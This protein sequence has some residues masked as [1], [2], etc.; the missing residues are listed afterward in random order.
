MASTPVINLRKGHA[1]RHNNEVCIVT[2]HELKTPPRMASYVQMS[3]RSVTT[4]KVFNLRLT[5]N[6]SLEGVMLERIPHE[7]SYK[8]SSGYHFLNPET[9][10][11]TIVPE[12]LVEPV[13]NYLID[14]QLYTILLA[15]GSV[16][17][18]DIPASMVMTVTESS[19]GV[20]GDSANNVYKPATM[21]TGLVVQVPLFI[22]VGER[23]NVKTEDNSYLGRA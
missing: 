18:I 17:A 4:K 20:K 10:D 9:Y 1:V 2:D 13:K 23:I 3:V 7:Y 15:D 11:D 8:D 5:S 21:E 12:D 22:N 19:E 6:N 16:A 14:G